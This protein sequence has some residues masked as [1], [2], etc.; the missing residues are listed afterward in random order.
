MEGVLS[1]VADLRPVYP[2]VFV[3]APVPTMMMA[4][5]SLLGR[6][7]GLQG[8]FPQKRKN[9]INKEMCFSTGNFLLLLLPP[10]F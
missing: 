3:V 10:C 2:S 6:G 4:F 8:S 9:K 5:W 7:R 1:P